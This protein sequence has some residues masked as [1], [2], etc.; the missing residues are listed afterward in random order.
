MINL[1]YNYFKHPDPKRAY[2]ID[3]C[4]NKNLQN[5][6]LNVILINHQNRLTFDFYFDKINQNTGPDDINIICNSDIF[7]DDTINL[8]LKMD[9]E[10]AYA[11]TR[12]DY[13]SPSNIKFWDKVFSQD[14]WIFKG[15]LKKIVGN[16]FLGR[17]G[18]DNRVAHEIK[19]SGYKISNPSL[20]IKTYHFH[21]SKIRDYK[22]K[23][24]VPGPYLHLKPIYLR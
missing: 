17:P 7:F 11:L 12:W 23:D 4:K 6:H 13:L 3:F 9:H 24:R 8:T 1:Y 16:Y 14:T 21:T 5:K 18:C 10:E 20:T 15:S 19:E 2:E 22:P